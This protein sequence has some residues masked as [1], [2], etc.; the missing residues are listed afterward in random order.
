MF[1]WAYSKICYY[2]GKKEN[3]GWTETAINMIK[4]EDETLR[5]ALIKKGVKFVNRKFILG[6]YQII[7]DDIKNIGISAYQ[8]KSSTTIALD[9]ITLAS[10]IYSYGTAGALTREMLLASLGPTMTMRD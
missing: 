3:E 8:K 7:L 9:F 2:T 10:D 6:P 4:E 1:D 5:D